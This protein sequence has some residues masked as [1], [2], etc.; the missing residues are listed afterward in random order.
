MPYAMLVSHVPRQK[1]GIYM[2][3]FN[4]FIVLPEIIS[5][6]VLGWFMRNVF[7]NNHMYAI[8]LGGFFMLIAAIIV[9]TLHKYEVK[10]DAEAVD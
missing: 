2:G 5:S 8:V 1:Y 6:L 4:M 9:Q 7:H 10:A 3:I